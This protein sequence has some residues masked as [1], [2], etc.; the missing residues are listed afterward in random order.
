MR[1]IEEQRPGNRRIA[2]GIAATPTY[3]Y[4]SH[5][6]EQQSALYHEE[7]RWSDAP[8]ASVRRSHDLTE[9]RYVETT[10]AV[11]VYRFV[12]GISMFEGGTVVPSC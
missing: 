4:R 9:I 7:T 6:V 1:L 11:G 8:G 5:R 10:F 12:I 3:L 2:Y